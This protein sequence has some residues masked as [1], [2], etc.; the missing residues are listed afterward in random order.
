MK[1]IAGI[2]FHKGGRI[3]YFDPG[4]FNLAKGDIVMVNTSFGDECGEVVI[5]KEIDPRESKR[6]LMPVTKLFDKKDQELFNK[7]ERE[8]EKFLETANQMVEKSGLQMKILDVNL[9]LDDGKITFIFSSESRVDF[10]QLVKDLMTKLKKQVVLRQ[11]GPRDEARLLG[12]YGRCGRPFCCQSFLQN[13]ESITIDMAKAQNLAGRGSN[14]ISGVCGKLM[15]CLAYEVDVYK[16]MA[17]GLPEI[18]EKIKTKKGL[19]LVI[20]QNI[21]KQSVL[22]ELDKDRVRFEVSFKEEEDGKEKE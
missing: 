1:S 7:K 8:K 5:L 14:K 16:E 11:I 19:G 21:I 2:R 20:D 22:V 18:G 15:C 12:G 17:K 13:L 10:R 4:S 6:D 3:Y 9:S